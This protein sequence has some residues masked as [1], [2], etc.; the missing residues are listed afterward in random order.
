MKWHR[1]VFYKLL[2]KAILIQQKGLKIKL[3]K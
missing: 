3:N 1:R 2:H